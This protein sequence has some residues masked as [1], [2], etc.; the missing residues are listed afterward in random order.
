M[1][2]RIEHAGWAREYIRAAIGAFDDDV[3]IE[4]RDEP[5]V[6][7]NVALAQVHATLALVEQQRIANLI[8]LDEA[9]TLVAE[10]ANAWQ[11]ERVMR[12]DVREGLGL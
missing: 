6:A 5:T 4:A 1:T 9:Y 7:E 12:T 8:T 10:D 3:T 2:E 11:S